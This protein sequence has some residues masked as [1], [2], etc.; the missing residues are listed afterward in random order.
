MAAGEK[1]KMVQ[2]IC[3]I[4]SDSSSEYD[5][6]GE[7]SSQSSIQVLL[8]QL[9]TKLLVTGHC[10]QFAKANIFRSVSEKNCLTKFTKRKETQSF[11]VIL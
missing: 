1:D 2:Q 3:D 7:I 5:S 6:G 4:S 9:R 10:Y 8:K 11:I